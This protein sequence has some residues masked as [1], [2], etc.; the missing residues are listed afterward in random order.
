MIV[1]SFSAFSEFYVFSLIQA[2]RVFVSHP[3]ENFALKFN[4]QSSD[5]LYYLMNSLKFLSGNYYTLYT[6]KAMLRSP[7]LSLS[8]LYRISSIFS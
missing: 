4:L 6:S 5:N 7:P 1:V 3:H 2:V 8:L